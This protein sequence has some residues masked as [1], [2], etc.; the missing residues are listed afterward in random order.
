[1]SRSLLQKLD[2]MGQRHP[3]L[4]LAMVLVLAAIATLVLLSQSKGPAVLYQAF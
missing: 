1:M 3:G 2:A 4:E